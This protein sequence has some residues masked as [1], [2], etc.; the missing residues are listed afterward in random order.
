MRIT[1]VH[2]DTLESRGGA[3]RIASSALATNPC[4]LVRVET[5]EGL[6]GLRRGLPGL[7]VHR[8]HDVDC[9]T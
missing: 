8:R 4:D 9:R 6:T 2:V 7:R 5:D 3:L 1:A